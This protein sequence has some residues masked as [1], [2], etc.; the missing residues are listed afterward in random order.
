[1]DAVTGLDRMGIEAPPYD[2]YIVVR[3]TSQ[4]IHMIGKTRLNGSAGLNGFANGSGTPWVLVVPSDWPHPAE[5]KR[6]G[7]VYL[8][9]DAWVASQGAEHGNWYDLNA[10][11]VD[12]EQ[13]VFEAYPLAEIVPGK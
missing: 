12:R 13:V 5:G 3:Q 4:D 2:P 8:D 6:I 1:M 7:S 9:F 11:N 10:A